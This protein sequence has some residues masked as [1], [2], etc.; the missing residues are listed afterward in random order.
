MRVDGS[1]T[2]IDESV[3]GGRTSTCATPPKK[4]VIR[5]R[6]KGLGKESDR[7]PACELILLKSYE[8]NCETL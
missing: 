1:M 3:L 8:L 4:S 7:T 2:G 5:V 6:S